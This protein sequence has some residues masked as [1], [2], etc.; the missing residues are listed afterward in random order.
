[1]QDFSTIGFVGLGVMG[2][3]MCANL[4]RKSGLEVLAHDTAEDAAQRAA[5]AGAEPVETLA[6]L[7]EAA[8]LVLLSLPGAPQVEAV[9]LGEDGILAHARPGLAV[10]DL[11]TT[12]VAAARRVGAALAAAGVDFADAPVTRTAQAAVEG[13]LSFMVG[14]ERALFDRLVPI[15]RHMGTD[16]SH[17]GGVGSGQVLKLLNNMVCMQTVVALAE[18]LTMGRRAGVDGRVLFETLTSGSADSFALRNH[19][20]KSMLPGVF[21][22]KTYSCLYALKDLGYALELAQDTGVDAPG[23]ALAYSLIEAARDMG[24]GAKYYPVLLKAVE[25]EG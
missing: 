7:V 4:V 13:T 15:F 21:A 8:D 19:G 5:A 10:A 25:G 22:E 14:G 11:S 6:V 20:M 23:A 18:A 9:C 17:C 3:P 16:F 2:A 12:S 24:H 1:M